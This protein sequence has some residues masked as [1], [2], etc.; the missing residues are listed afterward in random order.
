MEFQPE[1]LIMCE[2]VIQDL[3]LRRSELQVKLKTLGDQASFANSTQRELN[4]ELD[5][6]NRALVDKND[7]ATQGEVRYLHSA[8]RC[9]ESKVTVAMEKEKE[10][11]D[12]LT[13]L[14]KTIEEKRKA[15]RI[16]KEHFQ[17][18]TGSGTYI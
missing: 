11:S 1:I 9:A 4:T 2:K 12:T 18:S 8:L 14:C 15:N 17:F 6:A 3:E 10:T 7:D 13:A 5:L 16:L